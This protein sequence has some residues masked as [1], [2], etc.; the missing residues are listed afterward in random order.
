MDNNVKVAKSEGLTP[1]VSDLTP[2]KAEQLVELIIKHE[3][4]EASRA[5]AL[6]IIGIAND[7]NAANRESIAIQAAR[8][9]YTLTG[10]FGDA[11]LRFIDS[12]DAMSTMV[13]S[14]RGISLK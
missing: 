11:L 6:L 10:A 1:Q 8:R 5:L 12:V 9:A 14:E 7:D 4:D 3:D 13:V 2:E